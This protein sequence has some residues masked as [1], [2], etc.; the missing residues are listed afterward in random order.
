[1]SKIIFM[2]LGLRRLTNPK[3][4]KSA[5]DV[6]NE[7][8]IGKDVTLDLRG[9]VFSYTLARILEA[10]VLNFE[11]IKEKKTLTLVHGYSTVTENH[12]VPYLTKKTSIFNRDIKKIEDLQ[13]YLKEFYNIE[14]NLIGSK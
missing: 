5:I 14:F 6:I 10:V 7:T 1:M 4:L 11:K 2:E 8:D 9:C 3:N 13:S 12:L